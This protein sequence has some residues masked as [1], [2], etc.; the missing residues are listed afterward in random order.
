[1]S[2]GTTLPPGLQ[3]SEEGE[4]EELAAAFRA[5][6]ELSAAVRA[7]SA[8]L[9]NEERNALSRW[10]WFKRWRLMGLLKTLSNEEIAYRG[11]RSADR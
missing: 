7:E 1:M 5:K 2:D 8:H 9:V 11:K 4:A 10:R 3:Y 6:P